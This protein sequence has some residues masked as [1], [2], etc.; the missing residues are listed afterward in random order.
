MQAGVPGYTSFQ[1]LRLFRKWAP[2][3]RPDWVIVYVA[4]ND[5]APCVEMPD[6][7]MAQA[8]PGL[9][10]DSIL[11][12]S[13]LF[14]LFRDFGFLVYKQV[15]LE[16][17][18]YDGAVDWESGPR[19]VSLDDFRENLTT[20]SREAKDLSAKV[21]LL[22]QQHAVPNPMIERYNQA[23]REVAE[24]ETVSFVDVAGAFLVR[25]SSEVF[26]A[27]EADLVHPNP[28][29]YALIAQMTVEA[30]GNQE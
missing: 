25:P 13:R 17:R 4:T 24:A 9:F 22:N 30:M 20:L 18:D 16:R 1:T 3:Y 19:R 27:P 21:I 8:G 28:I 11:A 2:E 14:A 5:T 10:E 7:E 26:L 12:N 29:G 15:I 6:K 23:V